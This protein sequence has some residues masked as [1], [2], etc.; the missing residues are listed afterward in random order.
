MKAGDDDNIRALAAEQIGSELG[1]IR[2][3]NDILRRQLGVVIDETE[4][5]A[6][7][8]TSRL[9]AVDESVGTLLRKI[10]ALAGQVPAFGEVL[11]E[12]AGVS[13]LLL[14]TIAAVQFQ[15]VT[16][17]QIDHI[18]EALLRLDEHATMMAERLHHWDD[19]HFELRPLSSHMAELYERYVSHVQRDVHVEVAGGSCGDGDEGPRAELF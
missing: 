3:F 19:P 15:D 1:Q 11:T 2:P 18:R 6:F 4:K 16:R 7:D 8:I 12:G 13:S 9:L 10:E 14:E 17:Q 5:A